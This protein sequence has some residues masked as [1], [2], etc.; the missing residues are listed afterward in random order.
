[1]R[2]CPKQVLGPQS[3]CSSDPRHRCE[4]PNPSVPQIPSPG[5][6]PFVFW[7]PE[8]LNPIFPAQIMPLPIPISK[9]TQ[10]TPRKAAQVPTHFST[11]SATYPTGVSSLSELTVTK[12]P[13][14]ASET[15]QLTSSLE[16]YLSLHSIITK[17][18]NKL[19]LHQNH[20][21]TP[22]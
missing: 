19:L 17:T 22:L 14:R 4:A 3:Y 1:M 11:Y 2:G 16:T 10:E 21:R 6:A 5:M 8:P 7:H 12:P 18:C 20:Y 15:K 13:T 9:P